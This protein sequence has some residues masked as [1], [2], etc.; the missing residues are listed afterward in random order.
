MN[1]NH[2]EGEFA[3]SDE[4]N[5][6]EENEI[7]VRKQNRK[8]RKWLT[9]VEGVPSD[10]DI[11]DLLNILKKELCCNGTITIDNKNRKVIQ[12]Q[13]DHGKK[14]IEKLQQI[15]REHKVYSHGN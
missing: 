13:G 4:K 1:I 12:M 10:Y 15:F 7:H 14:I 6:F 11:N 3:F 2:T 5:G 8:G 9:T